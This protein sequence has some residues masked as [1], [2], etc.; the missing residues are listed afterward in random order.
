MTLL[1]GFV[2]QG[3]KKGAAGGAPTEATDSTIPA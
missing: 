2:V 1:S 3:A